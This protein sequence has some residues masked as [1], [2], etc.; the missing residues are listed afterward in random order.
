MR[1]LRRR[2]PEW[3]LG[4][5]IT[6]AGVLAFL[7]AE[8]AGLPQGYWTVFTAVLVTQASVGGSLKATIDRLVGTIAGA[9]YG[10]GVVMLVPHGGVYP[11]ALALGVSLAPLALFAAFHPTYRVAPVTA[12]IL[13]LGS[14]GAQEGPMTAAFFRTL[15][16]GLGGIIGIAVSLFVFPSRA[17]AIM[18][19]MAAKVL[20]LFAALLPDLIAA[21]TLPVKPA[22]FSDQHAAIQTQF[23]R[24][25]MAAEEANRERR[26]FRNDGIDP[27]PLPRTLR[28]VYHDIV[29]VGRVAAEPVLQ[30][31]AERVGAHLKLLGEEASALLRGLGQA[32]IKG[33]LPPSSTAFETALADCLADFAALR[34]VP[35]AQ[36]ERSD[37]LVALSFALEQL[38]RNIGD[39]A[40]RTREFAKPARKAA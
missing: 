15:E 32:L 29:L 16:V 31:E 34:T 30:A 40:A 10:A 2:R 4:L 14:A 27:D 12:V 13:L 24:M 5:R 9:I 33:E 26:T 18:C 25:E 37:R 17:H 1:W 35:Q 23:D 28:R 21:L 6:A 38:Q 20:Q 39:L 19:E 22:R 8:R 11:M 7:L 36:A 3:S